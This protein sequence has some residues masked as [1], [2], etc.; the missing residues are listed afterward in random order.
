MWFGE[1]SV[2]GHAFH[3]LTLIFGVSGSLMISRIHIPKL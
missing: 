2:L 1:I 3:P